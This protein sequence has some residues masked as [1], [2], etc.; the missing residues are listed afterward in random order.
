MFHSVNEFESNQYSQTAETAEKSATMR[1]D[2][3][4]P[5]P[6][7]LSEDADD[8]VSG[9]PS[10]EHDQ[11]GSQTAQALVQVGEAL[12]QELDPVEAGAGGSRGEGRGVPLQV[13]GVEHEDRVED[14]GRAPP[15]VVQRRVVVNPKALSEPHQR[16][17]LHRRR[18]YSPT[19]PSS[20]DRL[21][22]GRS[23]E[24]RRRAISNA[25]PTVSRG[26]QPATPPHRIRSLTWAEKRNFRVNWTWRRQW[27]P[28]AIAVVINLPPLPA[29]RSFPRP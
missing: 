9:V 18:S 7:Y 12:E 2:R 19:P 27:P 23:R 10:A 5:S 3:S 4:S 6:S 26:R 24:P 15:R 25:R 13:P 17:R 21:L 8:D 1:R 20:G 29:P 28:P 16:V 14:P 22:P 11:A